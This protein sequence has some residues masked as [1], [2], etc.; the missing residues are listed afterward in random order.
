MSK[1]TSPLVKEKQK[2][3]SIV[4]NGGKT[5][6]DD[7][8]IPVK[9][10]FSSDFIENEPRYILLVDLDR[11]QLESDCQGRRSVYTVDEVVVFRQ[12]HRSGKHIMLALAFKKRSD[13]VQYLVRDSYYYESSIDP[14]T[15][16][17]NSGWGEALATTFVEFEVPKELFAQPPKTKLG[18]LW[19]KYIFWPNSPKAIDECQVQKLSWFYSLP[20][21]PFFIL[22]KIMLVVGFFLYPIY[23]VIARPISLFI[24]WWPITWEESL[25][26]M[27]HPRGNKWDMDVRQ[28]WYLEIW[29]KGKYTGKHMMVSPL[30]ATIFIVL[31]G[32]TI[33]FMINMGHGDNFFFGLLSL[34]GLSLI[35]QWGG[36]LNAFVDADKGDRIALAFSFFFGG[37]V[38]MSVIAIFFL[39]ENMDDLSKFSVCIGCVVGIILLLFIGLPLLKEKQ[40]DIRIRL[41]G[42]KEQR[43]A[44]KEEEERKNYKKYLLA[45]TKPEDKVTLKN[46]PGTFESN[47]LRRDARIKFWTAKTKVCRPYES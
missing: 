10:F 32:L 22:A 36:I 29:R 41:Q 7:A 37:W 1:K 3:F 5:R 13:A 8:T 44:E 28:D 20:K 46:L 9:W 23:I 19:W 18:K 27:R 35:S 47:K 34:A 25:N 30:V 40:K 43:M 12:M 24:G 21:L 26:R 17:A 31:L 14:A 15:I 4:L 16:R 2:D 39:R 6:I 11:T 42:R 45:F 38:L 33:F